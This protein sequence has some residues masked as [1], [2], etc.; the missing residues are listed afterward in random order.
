M[1]YV[2]RELRSLG[3]VEI[4]GVGDKW[5]YMLEFV[6]IEQKYTSTGGKTGTISITWIVYKSASHLVD[7]SS[8]LT[9]HG[10]VVFRSNPRLQVGP[11]EDLDRMCK[12]M[13]AQFDTK[14]LEVI[15]G[16]WWYPKTN[17]E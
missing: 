4:V 14:N 16:S 5:D 6:G 11:T 7:E 17:K 10:E 9:F 1:S 15:R 8:I 12:E 2:K 3:D 13:V